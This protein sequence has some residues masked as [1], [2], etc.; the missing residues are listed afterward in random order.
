[1]QLPPEWTARVTGDD[2]LWRDF[3]GDLRL[4]WPAVRYA[5]RAAGGGA[6]RPPRRGVGRCS[7]TPPTG[8][9]RRLDRVALRAPTRRRNRVRRLSASAIGCHRCRWIL[10]RR[11]SMSA[12]ARRRI[13]RRMPVSCRAGSPSCGTSSCSPPKP[14]TAAEKYQMARERGA[15]G[16]LIA[17]P[18]EGHVVAGSSG[19]RRRRRHSRHG[20]QCRC[21]RVFPADRNRLSEVHHDD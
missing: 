3:E 12:A 11:W 8:A 1:M 14:C 10:Q 7:D 17:G 4:W 5:E 13:S 15:V 9:L 19:R 20:H 16:F 18:L 6:C 21:S 2:A